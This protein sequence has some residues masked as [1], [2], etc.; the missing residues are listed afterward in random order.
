M[1]TRVLKRLLKRPAARWIELRC[2][3]SRR[4]TGLAL[5]YHRVGD[6][7]GDAERELVPALGTADFEAQVRYLKRR[8]RLVPASQLY[9][10]ARARRR[11][12]RFPVAITFDDDLPSHARE[13][14]PVLERHR[15]P[16]TFFLCGASLE[17]PFGFW[18]ERLQR[19]WDLG[20]VD[21][22]VLGG[23]R[24][25][26]ANAGQPTIKR[27]A[28]AIQALPAARRRAVAE[29]LVTHAGPDPQ[30]SGMR[31]DDVKRLA[32]AEYEIGFHTL[33]HDALPALDDAA[34]ATAM[35]EGK[36]ALE[37]AAE[38]PIV[39]ISYPHGKADPR[40]ADAARAAGYRCGFTGS[41]EAVSP[42]SDPLLLGR[43]DPGVGTVGDLA[44][45][46]ARS[47][48]DGSVS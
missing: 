36:S 44:L 16:A 18:W 20:A 15:A 23:L 3:W 34:L 1:T 35:I 10:A 14:M 19:A 22:G 25:D 21:G 2:R 12:D 28:E 8:W 4:K 29:E 37:R 7:E 6:P 30:D 40:V 43:H 47:L 33:H 26:E 17:R 9:E 45:G 13:A 11:G 24:A 32:R 27:V 42:A 41:G 48:R 31:A 46:L 39:A 5:C 38:A